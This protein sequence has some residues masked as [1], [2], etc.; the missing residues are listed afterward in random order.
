MSNDERDDTVE[1]QP[2]DAEDYEGISEVEEIEEQAARAPEADLGRPGGSTAAIWVIIILVIAVLAVAAWMWYQGEARKKA[3]ERAE[4]RRATREGQLSL[5]AEDI[6][7]AETALVEGDYERML[8]L[9]K[10]MDEQ[11]KLIAQYASQEDDAEAA[12]AIMAMQRPV[13]GAIDKIQP[14]YEELKARMDALAQDAVAQLA[15]VRRAFAGYRV[16]PGPDL[17]ALTAGEEAPAEQPA[18]E[19]PEAA[20]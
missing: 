8:Q 1:E 7:A 13:K 19:A 5:V 6:A 20:P 17:S 16:P 10:K 2:S 9:L 15:D 11:L 4:Q 12:Q 3:E 18:G 14:Q